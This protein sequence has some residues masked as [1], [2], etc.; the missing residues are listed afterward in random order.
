MSPR[1]PKGNGM[2][3][4]RMLAWLVVLVGVPITLDI[5][6]PWQ[7]WI[8]RVHE[9]VAPY[10]SG[11]ERQPAQ[12]RED[13]DSL[14]A[15]RGKDQTDPSDPSD[16]SDSPDQSDSSDPSDSSDS[17]DSGQDKSTRGP[18]DQTPLEK[19]FRSI[20]EEVLDVLP[21][22]KPGTVYTIRTRD[23]Q[24]LKGRLLEVRPGRLVLE[25]EYGKIGVPI[26]SLHPQEIK[27][28]FP[29]R[30]AKNRALEILAFREQRKNAPQETSAENQDAPKSAATASNQNKSPDQ[31]DRS[32]SDG[33]SPVRFNPKP[34]E[35]DQSLLPLVQ[36]FAD[37]LEVQHRRVGGSV[38][39]KVFAHQQNDAAILYLVLNPQFLDQDYEARF[40]FAESLWQFWG[41]RAREFGVVSSPDD[42]YIVL[43]D[44]NRKPVGGSKPGNGSKVWMKG[45]GGTVTAQR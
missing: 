7:G 2:A 44:S 15:D 27:R 4:F 24:N 33:D 9:Q 8:S 42:A 32:P 37:W 43:L 13:Y 22:P 25:T 41:F 17:S 3:L 26:D 38:A 12:P 28:F 23:S 39:D 21:K 6:G 14:F 29:D 1:S 30:A 16:S 11:Q 18:E 20:Y 35:S 10:L 34:E 36:A 40:Q 5:V 31:T 45:G 19:E